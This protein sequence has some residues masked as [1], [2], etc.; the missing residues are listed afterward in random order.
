M[1]HAL[2][3]EVGSLSDVYFSDDN[4]NV[5]HLILETG[6]HFKKRKLMINPDLVFVGSS[7][8]HG[9]LNVNATCD[10]ILHSPEYMSD[11]PVSEQ[12]G[13]DPA[14]HPRFLWFPTGDSTKVV[15]RPLGAGA[16]ALAIDESKARA[17]G[18]NPHLRSFCEVR[19]YAVYQ[20]AELE[21]CIGHVADFA[22]TAE[23]EQIKQIV[24]DQCGPNAGELL[25]VLP[26]DIDCIDWATVRVFLNRSRVELGIPFT[27][28]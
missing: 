7:S 12:K 4:W 11:P 16:D 24:V 27:K 20:T 15:S 5:A 21:D 22:I 6:H 23:N 9:D 25:Y 13:H 3:G 8:L 2:D 1:V 19:G 28:V 10:D 26:G 17:Q 18:H 14:L